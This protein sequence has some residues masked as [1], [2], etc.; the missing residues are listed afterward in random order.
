MTVLENIMFPLTVGKKKISKNEAKEIA[1]EYMK[2]TNIEDL[3]QKNLERF[4]VVSNNEW[5]LHVHLF[6][7][8][9]SYYLM[10]H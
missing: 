3:G 6:K 7:N 8:Q 9:K 10:S 2:L 1:L 5:Q 4:P